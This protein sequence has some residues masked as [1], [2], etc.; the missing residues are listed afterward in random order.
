[1]LQCSMRL[2]SLTAVACHR[3]KAAKLESQSGRT[4]CSS[5]TSSCRLATL[6]RRELF[7]KACSA[8]S[9]SR[10]STSVTCTSR[11]LFKAC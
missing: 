10:A 5:R 4:L 2:S 11:K 6:D 3:W 9:V 7:S 1:M 8:L